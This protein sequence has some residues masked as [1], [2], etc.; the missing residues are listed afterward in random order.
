MNQQQQSKNSYGWPIALIIG[1][2]CLIAMSDA[3]KGVFIPVF[4]QVFKVENTEM[5]FLL[6]VSSIGYIVGTYFCGHLCDKYGQKKIIIAGGTMMII[7]LPLIVMSS[8]YYML[9]FGLLIMNFG[10]AFIALGINTLIP[11]I[12]VSFQAVLMNF[13]HFAYGFGSTLTQLKVG[14]L[15]YD[16][17]SWQTIYIGM[18][19]FACSLVV[20]SFFIKIP[21]VE[22]AEVHKPISKKELFK[23]PLLYTYILCLGFYVCAE[24][25]IGSWF[26]NYLKEVFAFNEKSSGLY[27]AMFFGGLTIGRLFGGFIT[28]KIGYI[29]T[30]NICLGV[31]M[32]LFPI[33]ILLKINGI[34]LISLTGLFCSIVFPTVILTVS[35]VFKETKTYATGIIVTLVSTMAMMGNMLIGFINDKISVSFGF[36]I[37]GVFYA[38]SFLASLYIY[39]SKGVEIEKQRRDII[40]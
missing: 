18:G 6:T 3:L 26:I 10:A 17:V 13:V 38:L 5:G 27:S 22:K 35:Y 28:E 30:V 23:N 16:G 39:K 20:L 40:T 11:L 32:I 2:M 8:S 29:K 4:K 34:Y 31:N 1:F 33:G 19:I 9:L 37:I 7:A 14:A 12:M 21:V 36:S 15:I 25:A 24:M